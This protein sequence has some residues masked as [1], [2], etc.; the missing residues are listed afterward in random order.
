[1]KRISTIPC[2]L[3][4]RS[5]AAF[6]KLKGR[7][8]KANTHHHVVDTP[9][10]RC[11]LEDMCNLVRTETTALDRFSA[12]LSFVFLCVHMYV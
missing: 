2:V 3:L 9:T 1:M 6:K 5:V 7:V 4:D 11:R 10:K 8:L 12:R